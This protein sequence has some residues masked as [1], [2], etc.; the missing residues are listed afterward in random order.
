M[1]FAAVVGGALPQSRPATQPADGGPDTLDGKLTLYCRLNETPL[2]EAIQAVR[3]RCRVRIDVDW[4]ALRTIGVER[5]T[6]VTGRLR[7][8]KVSSAL[9]VFCNSVGGDDDDH[10]VYLIPSDDGQAIGSKLGGGGW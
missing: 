7:V 9:K 5:D 8:L 6:P 1:V 4:T 3:D 10:R 2:S